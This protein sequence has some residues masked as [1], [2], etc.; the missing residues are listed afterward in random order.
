MTTE[1]LQSEDAV[2][3]GLSKLQ[4]AED[5]AFFFGL[6]IGQLTW[7]LYRSKPSDRYT[8]FEI[9]KRSG[10]VRQISAPRRAMR[11]LH[12]KI[13]PELT[14]AYR[15]HPNAH[16]FIAGRNVVTNAE[17][18]AGQRWV[19][20]VDLE[21]FFPTINFGRVRGL[22]MAPPFNMGQK[23]AT[24]FA[25]ACTYEN[26][27]PQ[28]ACTS[29]VLSNLI[30]SELDRRLTRL[31]RIRKLRYSRYADDITFSGDQ[32]VFP[33]D[34]AFYEAGATKDRIQVGDALRREI[35]AAGFTINEGKVRM[36]Y[37]GVRQTVTGLTVNTRAN[38]E[39]SRI[40]KLRAMLHAWEK[41]GAD[42][43]G[44]EYFGKYAP[45]S[46][47]GQWA[48]PAG[49]F[50]EVVYGQLAYVKMVRGAEDP[51]F[52][53]LAAKL[54]AVDPEP[55]RFVR[56]MVF[57]ADDYD[58][59]ISHASEDKEAIARPIF[60]A[61][62]GRGLKVFLD[63]AH[64][65]WGESFTM[66]INVALGAAKYV[67]AIVSKDSV[68]KEW[69]LTELNSAL[70]LEASGHKVVV[71]VMVGR[72]DLTRLPLLRAKDWMEW[73][74]D[75]DVVAERLRRIIKDGDA[76]KRPADAP[77][78]RAAVARTLASPKPTASP[79]SGPQGPWGAR[80]EPETPPKK[81][82]GLFGLFGKRKN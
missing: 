70:A 45:R 52:L 16:G 38:V 28:G 39:R 8:V 74:D 58:V 81:G 30:A 40:R 48:N 19:F 15:P 11:D 21:G 10:G 76:V 18:H 35:E 1:E 66:K 67:L 7:R 65:G 17:V 64:I 25:Q 59:F 55:S 2:A 4:T 37:R 29:P 61:C 42:A 68:S 69:P 32:L 41:F 82:R 60:E 23:A 22:F 73:S 43:A 63:E 26:G 27:L 53:N 31:A 36:Q 44:R 33:P 47:R 9:P 49:R 80:P 72:P 75:A 5:A 54:I 79:P 3:S 20:N 71:P 56:Q 13:L 46:I 57:K 78:A 24:L 62:A 77:A 34:V 12:E 6:K 14:A 51:V 50:R